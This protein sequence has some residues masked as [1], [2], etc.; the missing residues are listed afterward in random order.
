MHSRY[1][2]ICVLHLLSPPINTLLLFL[3]GGRN[4]ITPR[5]L[6][7]F[8]MVTINNFDEKTMY[9]IFSRITDWHFTIRY[10]HT[11]CNLNDLFHPPIKSTWW[12][13][14]YSMLP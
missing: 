12:C 7:H 2:I 6:R 13:A 10:L 8:N 14:E 4:P 5:Y 11:I 9:T 3:G 1:T